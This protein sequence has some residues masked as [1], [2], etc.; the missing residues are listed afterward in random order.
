M[1]FYYQALLRDP[2]KK[3]VYVE[4]AFFTKWWKEQTDSLKEQ[5]KMLVNEGRLEFIGGGKY[6]VTAKTCTMLFD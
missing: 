3:F 5:V 6:I 2:E 4:T 1:L